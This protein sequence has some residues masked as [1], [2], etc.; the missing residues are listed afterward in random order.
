[1]LGQQVR[2]SMVFYDSTITNASYLP[3]GRMETLIS[4]SSVQNGVTAPV[5]YHNDHETLGW[6]SIAANQQATSR[7]P[8]LSRSVS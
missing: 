7:H 1:M 2:Y 4:G 6:D 3:C 5:V 8:D